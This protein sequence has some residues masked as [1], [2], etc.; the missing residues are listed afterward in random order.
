M[1]GSKYSGSR[2]NEP[3]GGVPERFQNMNKP[4]IAPKIQSDFIQQNRA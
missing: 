4:A 1:S 2:G 3:R